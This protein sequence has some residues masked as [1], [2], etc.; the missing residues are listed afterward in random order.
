MR[1]LVVIDQ[2]QGFENFVATGAFQSLEKHHHVRYASLPQAA[3]RIRVDPLDFVDV[4]RWRA[5]CLDQ[6]RADL[7][8]KLALLTQVRPAI[9]R[10]RRLLR[11]MRMQRIGTRRRLFALR[12]LP[13]LYW[14]HKVMLL[15]TLL[16]SRNVAIA[17]LLDEETPDVVLHPSALN[18]DLTN[19]LLIECRARAIPAIVMMNSWDNPS[20]KSTTHVTPDRLLVW[21][22][23]TRQHAIRYM[24]L[25]SDAVVPLGAPQLEWLRRVD[26]DAPR[27]RFRI[28][29]GLSTDERI[30]LYAASSI[31]RGD[32]E[33]LSL[34]DRAIAA[35]DLP[36]CRILYRAYPGDIAE[37][38]LARIHR[39]PWRN[40]L[41]QPGLVHD[42]NVE[43]AGMSAAKVE[44]LA[45]CDAVISPFSTILLEAAMLGRPVLCYVPSDATALRF[46]RGQSPLVHFED[47]LAIDEVV[48]AESSEQLVP[49]ARRLFAQIA[50]PGAADRLRA[51]SRHFVVDSPTPY[52]DRL[53]ALVETM[54]PSQ[55]AAEAAGTFKPPVSAWPAPPAGCSVAEA[56]PTAALR[57]RRQS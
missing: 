32:F 50:N 53:L 29:H 7:W 34:L 25:S 54:A 47:F 36:P 33:A 41:I 48:L 5:V 8:N 18:G 37:P 19:D 28:R 46:H 38:E 27:Q 52:A 35:G 55:N 4:S 3:R 2:H 11:R 21:G 56:D 30:L 31:M 17:S 13:G 1:V 24:G 23:Q 43:C 15:R 49:A 45:A 16:Q 42:G 6:R 12:A 26:A 14:I 40:V 9:R 20:T 51:A 39:Q 22:E 57:Q 10:H 44:A